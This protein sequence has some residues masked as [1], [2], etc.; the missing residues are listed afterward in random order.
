LKG[1]LYRF[2]TPLYGS[3]EFGF[4][5]IPYE[6]YERAAVLAAAAV[7]PRRGRLG[8]LDYRED[9]DYRDLDYREDL[10]YRDLDYRDLDYRD[11]DYREDLG[12]RDEEVVEVVD[13]DQEEGPQ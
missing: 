3:Y 8:D 1:Y 7:L 2:Q 12:D 11:L 4:G 6:S 9:L 5:T 13:E 10:D